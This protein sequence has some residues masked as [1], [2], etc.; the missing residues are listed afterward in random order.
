MRN[1]LLA[2]TMLFATLFCV[3]AFAEQNDNPKGNKTENRAAQLTAELGLT[4]ANATKFTTIYAKFAAEVRA[5]QKQ[6]A[7][8]R[9]YKGK[10]GKMVE[11]TEQQIKQNLDNQFALSQSLLNIRKKY[12]REFGK[13]M[14]PSQIERLFAL[15]R[16]DA[17]RMHN[18][19]SKPKANAQKPAVKKDDKKKDNKKPDAKKADAKKKDSKKPEAKKND[20][21]KDQKKSSSSKSSSK[22]SSSKKSSTSKKSSSSKKTK[23]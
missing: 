14:Q 3:P 16:D 22:S 10:D 19:A 4:G 5:A 17:S 13:F 6:Y 23:K 1:L 2:F 12:Y 18:L 15:E 9:P 21:K 20:G 8:L 11:L 7:K